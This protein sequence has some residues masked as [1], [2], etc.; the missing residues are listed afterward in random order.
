MKP[1]SSYQIDTHGNLAMTYGAHD[2]GCCSLGMKASKLVGHRYDGPAPASAPPEKNAPANPPANT[3]TVTIID[4]KT[5]LWKA[6][7]GSPRGVE[8]RRQR[9]RGLTEAGGR[10][11]HPSP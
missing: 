8:A 2:P 4:G 7:V 11:H 6:R 5:A 9:T 1:V 10:S 3:K